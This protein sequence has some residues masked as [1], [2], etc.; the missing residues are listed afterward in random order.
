MLKFVWPFDSED[1]RCTLFSNTGCVFPESRISAQRRSSNAPTF[2]WRIVVLDTLAVCTINTFPEPF[3][4]GYMEIKGQLDATD[5]SLLQNL[6]FAQHVSG[7][8]MP[9][10]RSSRVLYR[11]L[12][13]VILGGY[14]S[15]L[16]IHN[17]QLH[18]RPTTCKP[19]HQV[20]QAATTC[21]I[22]LSP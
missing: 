16:R 18:T 22:L 10:I 2:Q 12:L 7:T 8:I 6:L 1:L 21:I 13:P 3:N 19:K 5:G 15:G 4:I 14:V 17:L 11:W 20:S 9:I